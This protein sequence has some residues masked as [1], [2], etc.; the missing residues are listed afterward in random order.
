MSP[1]SGAGASFPS[2][3]TSIR[4]LLVR[5][6]LAAVAAG[7]MVASALWAGLSRLGVPETG[8]LAAGAAAAAGLG[9]WFAN[10]AMRAVRTAID[11]LT[12]FVERM[13]AGRP[14]EL[15]LSQPE[16]LLALAE[17]LR[18]LSESF[19][20]ALSESARRQWQLSA[21]LGSLADGC[22]A[23]DP[24]GRIIL[25]NHAAG[26]LFGTGE[27]EA[28]G[29]PLVEVV[30][31]Y[32]LVTAVSE[33][34]ASGGQQVREFR[35]SGPTERT[36]QV[37]T[38]ALADP[39]QPEEKH[40]GAGGRRVSGAVALVRDVTELRRLER[41][42]TDFV[43]NVSHELR[44]P[45]TAIKGFIETLQEG[46]AEDAVTRRRFLDIMARETDR[47][48]ALISDLLDLSRLE[49]RSVEFRPQPVSLPEVAETV[50]LLFRAK[51][52]GKGLKLS[53]SFP[54]GLPPVLADEA[55]LRQVFINL[56]DNAVKYTPS[57]EIRVRAFPD[58]AA[59]RVVVEVSDTGIGIPR[60]H[61]GRIFER[62]Y[63]V[64]RARS[65][66][67]GG[68]GLGLS[69][70]RHIVEL[71]G[72]RVEVESEVGVGSTFRFSLPAVPSGQPAVAAPTPADR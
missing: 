30:R 13:G 65:R 46:A 26:R 53:S 14:P 31:S 10:G 55:M 24:Q 20:R 50:I 56:L 52:E 28:L 69:I 25:F 66:E 19:S 49:S 38:T 45:L 47:L 57:G 35:L 41:V 32:D 8:A 72:G 54:A 70:V 42:R 43:A 63:R 59:G 27:Q 39:D 12:A 67:L 34:L 33:T 2:G 44:T 4:R 18:V 3:P 51:A 60:Q 62:F 11:G 5:S 1:G 58:A 64:D 6:H 22:I 23:V 21:V 15:L 7:L 61:L 29:R 68:T 36:L 71:H 9:L 17:E 37:T 16:E 40:P 48:V